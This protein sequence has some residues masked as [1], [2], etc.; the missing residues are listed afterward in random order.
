MVTESDKEFLGLLGTF[1]VIIITSF[2]IIIATNALRTDA[3]P[4]THSA[5]ESSDAQQQ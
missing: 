5:N 2:M 4:V 1:G 3:I